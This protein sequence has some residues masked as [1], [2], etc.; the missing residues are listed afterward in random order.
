MFLLQRKFAVRTAEILLSCVLA[1]SA[2]AFTVPPP[3][4]IRRPSPWRSGLSLRRASG[5]LVVHLGCGDGKLTAALRANESYLVQGLDYDAGHVAAAREWIRSLGLYG[6]VSAEPWIGPRLPYVDNLVNL[7]VCEQP[8]QVS[9]EEI[10]RVF[11]PHGVAYVKTGGDWQK[12]VKPWPTEIDEWTHAMHGPDNN[13]VAHDLVVGPPRYLQWVGGPAWTRSHDH[14]ASVSV[15][16]SS[17]GRLFYIVDEGP[18]A[19]VALPSH[20]YLAARDAFNGVD[21]WKRRIDPGRG[22]CADFAPVRSPSPGG[23]SPSA[24][25]SMLPW[26][27]ASR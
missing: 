5:G 7:L 23:W 17:Q 19:A 16:V 20:W 18:I 27:T 26:A 9:Q 21:L 13:A 6:K 15:V 2:G 4:P 8:S 3:R 22:N 10:V 25:P 12:T 24:I 11:A 1:A 14:L